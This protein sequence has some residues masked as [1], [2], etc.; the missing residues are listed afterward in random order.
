MVVA[1]EL[2]RN[3]ICVALSVLFVHATDADACT[4]SFIGG[5]LAR[6]ALTTLAVPCVVGMCHNPLFKEVR[7]CMR[8][9]R[10][11]PP[12]APRFANLCARARAQEHLPAGMHICPAPLLPHVDRLI[13]AYDVVKDALA[14][15]PLIGFLSV[16][17]IHVSVGV[18]V[19]LDVVALPQ[20]APAILVCFLAAVGV[21]LV[22]NLHVST[23]ANLQVLE[24]C[25]GVGGSAAPAARLGTQL[26]AAV[27][28]HELL[29]VA[30]EALHDLFPASTSQA[31]ATLADDGQLDILEVAAVEQHERHALH[32]ALTQAAPP[33]PPPGDGDAEVVSSRGTSVEFVCSQPADHGAVIVDSAEW[34]ARESAFR[35][36]AAAAAG[37]CSGLGGSGGQFVTARLVSGT[38]AVV[39]FVVLHFPAARGFGS[40]SAPATLQDF[41]ELVGNAVTARRTKDVAE[42]NARRCIEKEREVLSLSHLARDVFP[43]HL[44]TAMEVRLQRR[45]SFGD[46]NYASTG[47]AADEHDLLSDTYADVSIVVANVVGFTALAAT[48]PAEAS[49][50]LLDRL[51]HRFD[52]LTTGAVC[53]RGCACRC[54]R[55]SVA[56]V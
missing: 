52:T 34:P 27:S 33:P 29:R 28:E 21:Q 4:P 49:M 48:M 32:S 5:L 31:L 47:D 9:C 45:G 26:S 44:V 41:C 50:R 14:P 3:L 42:N 56:D 40:A 2:L 37:G 54:M 18:L 12:F 30:A 11:S 46:E 51:F 6:G 7:A 38:D 22:S 17:A 1:P 24:R 43:P 55:G 23:A 39:G 36:W 15:E 53:M 25:L 19:H 16:M 10:R 35:D 8:R 20:V 13:R